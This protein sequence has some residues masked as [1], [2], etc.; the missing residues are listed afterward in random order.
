MFS[1]LELPMKKSIFTHPAI[2]LGL[3]QN[4][5]ATVRALA[6]QGVP[7]LGVEENLQQPSARTRLCQ[8]IVCA[9]FRGD[10]LLPCLVALGQQLST[11]GV[12]FPSG[13]LNLQ[14]VS[15]HR[16]VL[17]DYYT[18]SLP[19]KAVIR[20]LLNKQ[21]FYR[22]ATQLGFSVPQTY[23][24][25]NEEEVNALSKELRF[26]C[27][28]K[29]FQPSAAWRQQFPDTKLIEVASA[30]GLRRIYPML[31]RIH[32]DLLIQERI[33][34]PDSA[35]AFSL[36][37]FD[38]ERVLGMFTGRKLRQ[39]PLQYGTSC[40]TE[41]YWNPEI[42]EETVRLMKAL[43]YQ[44]YGSVEFKWDPRDQRFKIIEFTPRTWFP[45]GI[46]AACGVNLPYLM[47]RHL[48]GFPVEERFSFVEGVKWIHEER[49]LRAIVSLW[50][51]GKL[52][53]REILSSYQGQRTYALAAFDDPLPILAFLG[54]LLRQSFR[55]IWRQ[56]SPSRI[57][58]AGQQL[59]SQPGR[60][61]HAK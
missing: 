4:G 8:K 5:L 45:H 32:A 19:E 30:E 37:Y 52:K 40:V 58:T 27:I 56:S 33:P 26:P 48:L 17:Q 46:S 23:F 28:L 53:L 36:V 7:V 61:Y 60:P 11:K 3:G 16:D 13:D 12:L 9:D 20:L 55:L 44:G 47:Y 51:Q 14:V 15:E 10:G 29:P 49:E 21:E 54:E 18:F 31:R 24:P 43:G 50:R 35:L 2:V 34:G 1:Y 25:Q 39:F 22:V 57:A 6:R 38:G 42:I 41:S 59:L